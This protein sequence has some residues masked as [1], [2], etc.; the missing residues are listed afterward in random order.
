MRRDDG[1]AVA[2]SAYEVLVVVEG[3]PS[4]DRVW[5]LRPAENV[6]HNQRLALLPRAPWFWYRRGQLPPLFRNDEIGPI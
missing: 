3:S 4:R 1:D 2:T 5:T 6:S